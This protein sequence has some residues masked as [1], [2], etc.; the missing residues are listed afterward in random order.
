VGY[1]LTGTTSSAQSSKVGQP[2]QC[3]G[4]IEGRDREDGESGRERVRKGG[5]EERIE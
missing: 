5:S 2:T 3:S 1:I 4:R